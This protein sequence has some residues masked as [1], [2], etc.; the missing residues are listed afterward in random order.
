MIPT[1]LVVE[2]D[3]GI[4]EYLKEFLMDAGYSVHTA[5]DGVLALSMIRKKDNLGKVEASRSQ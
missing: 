3:A 5:S 4:Q 2:D 1:I